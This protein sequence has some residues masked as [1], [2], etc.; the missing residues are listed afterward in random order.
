MNLYRVAERAMSMDD[1]VW[2]RHAN[3]WS[4]WTRMSAL[5]L[6]ALAIWSRVWLGWGALIAVLLVL[7][8]VWLNP[9]IFAPPGDLDNWMS[10]GVMG[11]RIF[12]EHRSE[13]PAH[14]RRAALILSLLSVPG[15]IVMAWGLWTYWW[16][17]VVF[18][19]VLS[20]LPKIWF[21]DRMVWIYEDWCRE[22]R[23]VPGMGQENE[24][25]V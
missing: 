6:L 22:G 7:I 8:W 16:E 11:E 13:V 21:V 14:Q 18:G 2:R 12:L 20:M 23:A 17:G 25:N 19:T 4:G 10:K 9:R 1:A 24:N 5:P 3:P 15:L